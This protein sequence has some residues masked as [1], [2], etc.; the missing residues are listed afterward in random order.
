MNSS[1]NA[2]TTCNCA[3]SSIRSYIYHVYTLHLIIMLQGTK[4]AL[5]AKLDKDS[6]PQVLAYFPLYAPTQKDQA[7]MDDGNPGHIQKNTPGSPAHD[8]GGGARRHDE[9]A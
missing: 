5:Y 6:I 1:Q 9:H 7:S 8:R 3:Y 4:D 2:R